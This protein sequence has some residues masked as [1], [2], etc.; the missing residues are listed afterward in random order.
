[1]LLS[2][3]LTNRATHGVSTVAPLFPIC[4]ILLERVFVAF[5]DREPL[6]WMASPYT[7]NRHEA[8]A[9]SRGDDIL[10]EMPIFTTMNA[11]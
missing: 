8:K 6:A 2:S 11:D 5:A 7:V 3:S 4:V 1:M 10:T 9:L